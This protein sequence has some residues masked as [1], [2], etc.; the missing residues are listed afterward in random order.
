MKSE[1]TLIITACDRLDLL[2]KTLNSFVTF[3]TFPIEELIIRDDSGVPEVQESMISLLDSLNLPFEY[4]IFSNEQIGQ[5]KSIDLL[6]NAVRTFYVFHCE[7]DWEFYKPGFIDK[8]LKILKENE[9]VGFVWLRDPS[10]GIM[11][12]HEEIPLNPGDSQ[13]YLVKRNEHSNGFSCNPH[14][15]RMQ[16]YI[17]P[18]QEFESESAIGKFYEVM[19]FET[20]WLTEGY[21]RH[22]GENKSTQRNGT[23]YREGIKK[24]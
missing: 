7:D 18:Y 22:I 4:R 14:L 15:K 6:M 24:L 5:A 9:K 2:E 19:G 8:S 23:S 16:D 11:A 21:V 10:D 20:A 3:N 13:Y 17:K 1:V 12:S